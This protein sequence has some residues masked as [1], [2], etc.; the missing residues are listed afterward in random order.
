MLLNV[1]CNDIKGAHLDE[2]TLIVTCFHDR[3]EPSL[4]VP[5]GLLRCGY[6]FLVELCRSSRRRSFD[7]MLLMLLH[8][9]PTGSSHHTY[10]SCSLRSHLLSATITMSQCEA[11]LP[12]LQVNKDQLNAMLSLLLLLPRSSCRPCG[13]Y[14]FCVR[15]FLYRDV[16]GAICV[17]P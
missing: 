11:V 16:L 5:F 14:R 10:R 15:D 4:N 1:I 6:I 13:F 12:R 7:E 17:F 2:N 3:L 9:V 8:S